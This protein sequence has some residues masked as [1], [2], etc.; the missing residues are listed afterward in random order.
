MFAIKTGNLVGG[1]LLGLFLASF[2]FVKDAV[3][4]PKSLLGITLAFSVA[5]AI[6]AL[7]K[8][9]ALLIYPLDQKRVDEVERELAAR[10]AAATSAPE[11]KI[12]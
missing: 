12:A 8:A 11:T 3:Q 1:F 10:R 4:T 6:F 2:S 7:L 5:P 9:V